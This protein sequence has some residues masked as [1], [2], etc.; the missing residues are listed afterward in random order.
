MKNV[1]HVF[2]AHVCY[3]LVSRSIAYNVMDDAA[4]KMRSRNNVLPERFS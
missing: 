1:S 4:P 2:S 3:Y